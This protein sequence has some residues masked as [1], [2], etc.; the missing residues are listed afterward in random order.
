MGGIAFSANRENPVPSFPVDLHC[1][2]LP[3]AVYFGEI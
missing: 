1:P 3:A 2:Q